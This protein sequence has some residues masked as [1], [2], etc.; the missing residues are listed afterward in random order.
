MQQ[1]SL[2]F[3]GGSPRGGGGVWGHAPLENFFN[4]S[5]LKWLEIHLKLTWCGKNYICKNK[6]CHRKK[7]FSTKSCVTLIGVLTHSLLE[8]LPKNVF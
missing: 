3:R 7:L 5:P 2:E 8:M 6:K 1:L 4:L